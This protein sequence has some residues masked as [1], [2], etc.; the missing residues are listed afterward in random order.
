LHI[1]NH[2]LA[3]GK[4]DQLIIEGR[5]EPPFE[6]KFVDV[7]TYWRDYM[8]GQ[9]NRAESGQAANLAEKVNLAGKRKLLDL[10]GGMGSYTVP[11]CKENPDLRADIVDQKEPLELALKI[12]EEN[13]LTDRIFLK[14][15]DFHTIELDTDYDAVLVSGVVCIK[16]ETE[17]ASV[18]QRAF[19]AL[20]P[21]GMVIVQDFMRI[22][23]NP[24]KNFLDTMMDLYLKIAFNPEAGD[25]AGE[26][27]VSWL[28]G[29]GF[30]NFKQ[31][32]LPTQLNII[33][34][35]KPNE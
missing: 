19:N 24:H 25:F 11:L 23:D 15:G 4:L 27:V 2:W 33:T 12:V 7:P 21:G 8:Y 18:F 3:W 5:T 34:A 10:G 16:S 14:E 26:E 9:H 13:N 29:T 22:G 31:I 32:P 20:A 30:I 28:K 6:N 17:C 35:E 1:T